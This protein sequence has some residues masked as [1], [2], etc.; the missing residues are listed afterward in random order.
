M[1]AIANT[2]KPPYYVV[3]FTSLQTDDLAG[4]S[5]MADRMEELAKEQDGY[6]GIESARQGVGITLSYW[7]DL[8]SIKKWKANLEHLDAQQQGRDRWYQS[9]RVRVAKVEREYGF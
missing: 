2:P 5:E 1:S 4:Y 9:Y 8:D 6:L 3:V 7:R